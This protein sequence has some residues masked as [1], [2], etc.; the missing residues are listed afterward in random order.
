MKRT[1]LYPVHLE[2][3]ARMV[4]FAGWEM[5]MWYTSII[6][7]HMAVREKAGI[8]DV[9]HMGDI[10]VRGPDALEF[11]NMMQVNNLKGMPVGALKYTHFLNP[12]GKIIDDAIITRV[13]PEEFLC[14][15]NAA[16]T[17][18]IHRW[19]LDHAGGFDVSIEDRSE[20]FSIALQG[21]ASPQ[22]LEAAGGDTDLEFFT[23]RWMEIA[24]HRCM[25]ARSGYTGEDGFEIT[26]PPEAAIPVW[27]ALI[28]GATPCG[29]GARDTLRMEKCFLLSGQDFHE[30]RTPLETTYDFVVKWDHDFIGK[31]A[32]ER[33]KETDYPLWTAFI[34]LE[35]GV[36]RHGDAIYHEGEN[37]GTVT[38]GG[39]SPVL[40]KGIALGYVP[41]EVSKP[42]TRV[43]IEVR[44]RRLKAEAV[45]KP[46]V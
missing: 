1:P 17:A 36:P 34:L 13:G 39:M 4:E 32:L 31:E 3:N 22:V 45:K 43:E 9:S 19:L 5:P 24:G 6:E 21:P 37:V 16:M 15:P 38:S 10:F 7:E 40:K 23:M 30:D 28:G 41:R 27:N 42:G 33:Q 12:E 35:K 20:M 11:L 25:V 2:L 8:F 14:V 18:R 26:G 46:F 44:G 29:L